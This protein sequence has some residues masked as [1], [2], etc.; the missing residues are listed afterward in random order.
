MEED[1]GLLHTCLCLGPI[2]PLELSMAPQPS[3]LTHNDS[4]AGLTADTPWFRDFRV[5]FCFHAKSITFL[6]CVRP[7]HPTLPHSG[8]ESPVPSSQNC[9]ERQLVPDTSLPSAGEVAAVSRALPY[10]LWGWL[11]EFS[12][13]GHIFIANSRVTSRSLT[14][15]SRLLCGSLAHSIPSSK[16][17]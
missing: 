11:W 14:L 15:P 4:S 13:L 12:S 1:S 2:S 10:C 9:L 6:A 16:Q 3:M 17:R 5:L 8:S 7:L